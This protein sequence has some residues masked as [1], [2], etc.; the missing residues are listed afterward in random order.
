ML[1]T[2]LEIFWLQIYIKKANSQEWYLLFC[3]NGTLFYHENKK[4]HHHWW[5]VPH[6]TDDCMLAIVFFIF[7][8]IRIAF[9]TFYTIYYFSLYV[10]FIV[11]SF[12]TELGHYLGGQTSFYQLFP[13]DQSY[14]FQHDEWDSYHVEHR[15]HVLWLFLIHQIVWIDFGFLP[16]HLLGRLLGHLS[17]HLLN[18]SVCSY[19][20]T[21]LRAFVSSIVV[22]KYIAEIIRNTR[23]FSNFVLCDYSNYCL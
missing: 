13:N 17:C 21:S 18:Q 16:G 4:S 14:L 6:I 7:E 3:L 22:K 23:K 20:L 9:F 19:N 5:Y 10:S 8:S 11:S 12:V 15:Y 1:V 2:N